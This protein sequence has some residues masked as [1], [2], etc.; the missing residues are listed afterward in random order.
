MK[1]TIKKVEKEQY[2]VLFVDIETVVNESALKFLEDPKAPS[3]LV[4]PVKIA[5]AI[6]TR[7]QELIDHAP[8][9]SDLGKI[10]CIG[11]AVGLTGDIVTDVVNKK[12]TEKVVLERFWM[13]YALTHG[14]SAGYNILSFDLPFIM[15]RS[16]DLHVRPSIIPNLAKYR[17][18]PTTDLFMLLCGWNYVN[19]HKFKFVCARYGIP[20]LAVG[21]DGSMVKDMGEKELREYSFSDVNATRELYKRMRGFYF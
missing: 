4:D 20:L 1:K 8:L 16:F 5:A 6:A 18:D 10:A 3:N 15:K 17:S 11:Y 19:G 21:V 14:R 13:N 2:A 9:D 7:R 12:N